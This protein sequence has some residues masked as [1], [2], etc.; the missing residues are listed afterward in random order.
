[1]VSVLVLGGTGWLGREVAAHAAGRGHDVTCLAR[2]Q[3]GEPPAGASLVTGDR[4]RPDAYAGLPDRSWDLVVDVTSQPGYVRSAVRALSDQAGHWVYVSS[5][6]VYRDNSQPDADECAEVLPAL[7]AD[8]ATIEQY[9]E[10]KVAC[11]DALRAV[12]YDRLLVARPGLICGY[13]DRSDRFGYWPWRFDRAADATVLV[14]S[15][16]DA[17][18]QLLDVIDLAG[19]L[20]DAGLSGAAGTVNALGE[21]RRFGDVVAACR[22]AT[23]HRGDVVVADPDW[24]ID[25]GV[26]PWMGPRSL[27]VWTPGPEYAGFMARSRTAAERL[28]LPDPPLHRLVRSA[29]AW[30]RTLDPARTRRAGLTDDEQQ[31]LLAAL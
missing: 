16:L 2:G 8:E 29:L 31:Q 3:S 24:L 30:E 22:E 12:L 18:V 19:W 14:P 13:G 5:C 23:G 7:A 15:P 21:Q 20:V 1:V 25:Q 4:S 9:G 26:Q 17:P 28:G 10:G 11:E 6:S 27:P